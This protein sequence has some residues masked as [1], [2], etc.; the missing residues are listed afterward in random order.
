M[1]EKYSRYRILREFFD[2]PRRGFH[3]REISRRTLLSQPSVTIH[4]NELLKDNLILKEKNGIYPTFKANRDNDLFRLYKKNDILIRLKTT[5]LIDYINDACFP[6]SIILFGSSSK[7]EDIEESDIDLFIQ[8]KEKNLDFIKYEKLLNRK[9]HPF[10]KETFN[11][12]ADE[13]KN[14]IINGIIIKGYLKL[15]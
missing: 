7:G 2:F 15:F 4:L 9:I 8:S 3:I 1:I 10:F 6:K 12:L 13:I 14:N 5:G 11:S